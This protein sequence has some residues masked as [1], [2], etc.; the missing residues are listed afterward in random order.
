MAVVEDFA[1]LGFLFVGGD[2]LGLD[3]DRA[4]DQLGQHV[5]GRVE[6]GLRVSFDEIQDHRVGDEAGLDHFGHAADHFVAWQGLQRRQVHQDRQRLMKRP[7]QVLAG[8]GVDAG[9]A[10]DGRIDHAQQCGGQVHNRDA[11][12]PGGR[13]EPGDVGGGPAAEADQGVFAADSDA[14]QHLPDESH[15]GRGL[16]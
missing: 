2:H 12:Q 16:G 7:D 11:A 10:A 9:L 15:D 5:A 4:P 14:A 13:R 8:V 6:C 1:Q 3:G